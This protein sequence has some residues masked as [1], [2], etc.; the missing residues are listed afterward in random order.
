MTLGVA[1]LVLEEGVETDLGTS[2]VLVTWAEIAWLS[3]R[4]LLDFLLKCDAFIAPCFLQETSFGILWSTFYPRNVLLE[5]HELE[6]GLY[7]APLLILLT[8]TSKKR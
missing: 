3:L 5:A 7:F 4:V 1:P 2:A 6:V 8:L